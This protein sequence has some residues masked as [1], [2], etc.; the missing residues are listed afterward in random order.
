MIHPWRW[1]NK[2]YRQIEIEDQKH[3]SKEECARTGD[4]H[5]N[6]STT[7]TW[8]VLIAR[9]YFLLKDNMITAKTLNPV[10]C[11]SADFSHQSTSIYGSRSLMIRLTMLCLSY[12]L[13]CSIW[14]RSIW[15]HGQHF[16]YAGNV[17]IGDSTWL[18]ILCLIRLKVHFTLKKSK[19][20]KCFLKILQT[21]SSSPKISL[22]KC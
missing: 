5:W 15:S 6:R 1:N 13:I 12:W 20:S 16:S 21:T 2:K 19:K 14:I 11:N 7:Y 8:I 9:L 3:E 22:V 4:L 17:S 18:D 10:T